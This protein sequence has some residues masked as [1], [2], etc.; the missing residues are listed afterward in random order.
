MFMVN[1][2][3]GFY[4]EESADNCVT[5]FN[6]QEGTGYTFKG[7]GAGYRLVAI[8]GNKPNKI[9]TELMSI[10]EIYLSSYSSAKSVYDKA[11]GSKKSCF[12]VK[13][14]LFGGAFHKEEKVEAK[15]KNTA[16]NM[17]CEKNNIPADMFHIGEIGE[18]DQFFKIEAYRI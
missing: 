6:K 12:L 18:E 17:F 16:I 10:L 14:S 13:C 5:V 8:Q 4:A 15:D 3:D 1:F 11:I 7:F 2:G 9:T